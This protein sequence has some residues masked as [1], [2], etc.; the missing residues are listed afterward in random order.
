[1]PCE[2]FPELQG[3]ADALAAAKRKGDAEYDAGTARLFLA[4]V[5]AQLFERL[6]TGDIIQPRTQDTSRQGRTGRLHPR[7][8]SPRL[9][10]RPKIVWPAPL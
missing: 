2:R 3:A 9:R 6:S 5:Q 7:S 8:L 1:M 4:K 10:N